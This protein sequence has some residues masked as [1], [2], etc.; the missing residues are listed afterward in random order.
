MNRPGYSP[1]R[2]W[3]EVINILGFSP[4]LRWIIETLAYTIQWISEV[5]KLQSLYF[6][7]VFWN[8]LK[9]L[10]SWQ[11]FRVRVTI[12]ASLVKLRLACVARR[13]GQS[14]REKWAAK[15]RKRVGKQS[16]PQGETLQWLRYTFVAGSTRTWT[17]KYY[18]SW[19]WLRRSIFISAADGSTSDILS[20]IPQINSPFY[21]PGTMQNR[22]KIPYSSWHNR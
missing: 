13:S 7:T 10:G 21:R 3:G 4:T 16:E 6:Y 1:S 19:G 14:R 18:L 12:S 20:K 9:R 8:L 2:E 22:S 17:T 5:K 11:L 15:P